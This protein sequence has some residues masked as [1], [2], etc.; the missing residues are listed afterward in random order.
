[1][2]VFATTFDIL[3]AQKL[4]KNATHSDIESLKSDS[5]FSTLGLNS[6]DK[7]STVRFLLVWDY[8]GNT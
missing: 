8:D 6:S 3:M 1:M 2:I 7:F 4:L 5:N